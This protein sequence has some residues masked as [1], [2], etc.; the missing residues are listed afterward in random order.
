M[1]FLKKLLI[2]IYAV[3]GFVKYKSKNY[4]GAIE[5]YNKALDLDPNYTEAYYNRGLAK[6]ELQDYEGAIEDYNKA[7]DLDPNDTYAYNNRELAL[8]KLNEQN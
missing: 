8:Q 2:L 5:D 6:D 3:K 1:S 4:E 7:L